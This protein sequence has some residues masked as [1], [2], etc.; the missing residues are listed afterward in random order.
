MPAH[1]PERDARRRHR[2]AR[3]P[4]R[5]RHLRRAEQRALPLHPRIALAHRRRRQLLGDPGAIGVR[6][7]AR[8]E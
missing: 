7:S 8:C 5:V 6:L 2:D 4:L 3:P 1:R